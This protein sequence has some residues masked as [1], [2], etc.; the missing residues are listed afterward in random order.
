M[1]TNISIFVVVIQ[2]LLFVVT[3][4]KM[5]GLSLSADLRDK[6]ELKGNIARRKGKM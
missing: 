1:K 3:Y 4:S 2:E 5:A 6:K